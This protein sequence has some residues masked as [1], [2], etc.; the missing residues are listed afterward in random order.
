M[1]RAEIDSSIK[2]PAWVKETV[3]SPVVS[4]RQTL[5]PIDSSNPEWVNEPEPSIIQPV[6]DKKKEVE[7]QPCLT[8]EKEEMLKVSLRYSLLLFV[9]GLITFFIIDSQTTQWTENGL[10]DLGYAFLMLSPTWIVICYSLITV[11]FTVVNVPMTLLA[12]TG[13]YIFAEKFGFFL[14][15]C[16]GSTVN[17]VCFTLGA[18][19]CFAISVN[20]FREVDYIRYFK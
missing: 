3:V 10:K 2:G 19:I 9:I 7:Q 20:F 18:I 6:D 16:I 14:G 8:P 5:N 1:S 11:A 4:S 13:G 17:I 15:V 12:I